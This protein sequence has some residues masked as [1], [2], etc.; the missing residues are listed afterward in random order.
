M[1]LKTIKQDIRKLLLKDDMPQPV[2]ATIDKILSGIK[3]ES[4]VPGML[5]EYIMRV[6][7]D[8]FEDLHSEDVKPHKLTIKGSIE[9]TSFIGKLEFELPKEIV[10]RIPKTNTDITL[11][12]ETNELMFVAEKDKT[13]TFV[14]VD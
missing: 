12:V 10:E 1:E 6:M 11:I 8:F 5:A 13:E 2:V 9:S 7:T 14:R 3:D 4:D